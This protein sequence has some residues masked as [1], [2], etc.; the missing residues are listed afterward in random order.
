MNPI[1]PELGRDAWFRNGA[2]P[3][4]NELYTLCETIGDATNAIEL[5]MI[6]PEDTAQVESEIDRMKH[7]VRI[8]LGRDSTWEPPDGNWRM[9]CY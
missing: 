6:E 2:G 9:G 8:L 7:R 3:Y 5:E 1:D 4:E